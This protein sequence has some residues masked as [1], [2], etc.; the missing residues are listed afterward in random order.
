MYVCIL[1]LLR[2]NMSR[3]WDGKSFICT[4]RRCGKKSSR[5]HTK[6]HLKSKSKSRKVYTN[7]I[8]SWSPMT[9]VDAET[10]FKPIIIIIIRIIILLLLW[11]CDLS[12]DVKKQLVL[13]LSS[14]EWIYLCTLT[15]MAFW[16]VGLFESSVIIIFMPDFQLYRGD[17]L[18]FQLYPG[19]FLNS[20]SA[21]S[22][23]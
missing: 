1:H 6:G 5:L 14:G 15:L 10:D 21:S 9:F 7:V 20:N 22:V 2:T 8:Y 17:F 23:V 16:L 3:K 13:P 12:L 11:M 4:N 18:N 19:D